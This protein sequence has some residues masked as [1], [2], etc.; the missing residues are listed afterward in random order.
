M[1]VLQITPAGNELIIKKL[2]VKHTLLGS[3]HVDNHLLVCP[4]KYL[5]LYAS[6]MYIFICK[7]NL[8]SGGGKD[9]GMRW[10]ILFQATSN[11]SAV[12]L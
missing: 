6:Y 8:K 4:F 7:N 5:K 3:M 1:L 10:F 2:G 11:T 12:L 9:Q